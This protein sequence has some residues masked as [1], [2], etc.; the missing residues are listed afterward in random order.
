MKKNDPVTIKK[1]GPG[2]R[3]N[4]KRLPYVDREIDLG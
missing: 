4:P 3:S 1:N 2:F